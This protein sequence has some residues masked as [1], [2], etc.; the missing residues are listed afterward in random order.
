MSDERKWYDPELDL[1]TIQEQLRECRKLLAQKDSELEQLLAQYHAL[2]IK[3]HEF[4]S[5]Q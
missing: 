4:P 5:I 1:E 2:V 3:A